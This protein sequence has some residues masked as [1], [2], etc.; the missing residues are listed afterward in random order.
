[1]DVAS[2][3]RRFAHGQALVRQG[4][5]PDC[6]FLVRAGVVRLAAALPSG[7]EVVVG[8]LGPADVFGECALLETPP[9][10][11]LERPASC[12]WRPCR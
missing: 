2:P 8:M 9:R 6:L 4:Q 5:I 12:R 7:H 11:R 1:M 10:S 3:A